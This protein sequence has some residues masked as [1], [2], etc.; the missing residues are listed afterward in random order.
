M[1]R[2]EYVVNQFLFLTVHLLAVRLLYLLTLGDS[3]TQ[4]LVSVET[5]S[6]HSNVCLLAANRVWLHRK[7]CCGL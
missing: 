2:R 7:W 3:E 4:R 5:V 6:W 1:L